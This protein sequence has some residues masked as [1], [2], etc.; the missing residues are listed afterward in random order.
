MIVPLGAP[1]TRRGIRPQLSCCKVEWRTRRSSSVGDMRAYR[2]SKHRPM[3]GSVSRCV[4]V[5]R[6]I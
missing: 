5:T 6:P 4:M 3:A 1:G 2:M